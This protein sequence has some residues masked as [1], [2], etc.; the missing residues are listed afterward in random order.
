VR[1]TGGVDDRYFIGLTLGVFCFVL[2]FDGTKVWW[3]SGL[4]TDKAGSLPLG[5]KKMDLQSIFAL[6]I[7]EMGSRELFA[8]A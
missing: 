1:E 5:P 2:F 8:W 7:L 6:V 3:N 4:C